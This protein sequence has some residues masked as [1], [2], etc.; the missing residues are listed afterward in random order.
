MNMMSQI[1]R[2]RYLYLLA[3][4]GIL[5]FLLF[6]Y[7]PM[8]GIVIA[9]QNY[10]PFL[11]FF[12][13]EWVGFDHFIR[14]FNGDQFWIMFRNTL[15]ISLLNLIF[16]FPMPIILSLMLN[17]L[18]SNKYKRIIQTI[19]YLPHFLSW[20]I[21][22]G[23]TFLMISVS[24]GVINEIIEMMG[25]EKYPFLNDPKLFWIILT[26]QTMWKD[27]GWGTIIFLA[28][29]ASVDPQQYEA[30]KIDG[31]NRLRQMWHVTLPAIRNVITI[32]LILQLGNMLDIGFEQVFLM[33]N[34]AVSGVAEIFDTYV[35][36]TGIQQGQF[37]YSTAV[38]I[39]KSTVGLVLVVGANYLS[40]K[41][42]DEGVY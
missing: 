19:I 2:D 11:G 5:F 36:R 30:A 10:S 35:Y 21:I 42:G 38:G 6:K 15:A 13:S 41:L 17:E 33:Y 9:F 28:A 1:R 39:F 34:G 32:L 24:Q 31:A 25:Y 12:Q 18:R 23:L 22:V 4:P 16:F 3:L 40:K 7:L 14:L 29:M 37:S 20:V 8:F 27:A 26:V